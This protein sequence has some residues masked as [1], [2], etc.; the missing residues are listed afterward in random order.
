MITTNN[1]GLKVWNLTTDA[2]NHEQLADNWK[3]VDEHYHGDGT[4]VPIPTS[5]IQDGAI[6]SAK[7]APGVLSAPSTNSLTADQFVSTG[8]AD[9]L[10][11]SQ[12][13]LVRRGKSIITTEEARTNTA[14]GLL[15]TP[16]RVQ[17]LVVPTDGLIVIGFQGMVKSSSAA[18]G[19]AAIFI[20]SNQLKTAAAT[21]VVQEASTGSADTYY[22]YSTCVFGLD[23]NSSLGSY[24]GDVTTGQTLGNG[25]STTGLS[26][27]LCVVFANA[28]TYD[29]SIQ[30]KASTGSITA[31]NRKLWVWTVGF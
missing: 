5:G 21:P 8:V 10:G 15:T 4:G 13:G 26:G 1:M 6:T 19:K 18:A 16:D 28:G 29:I 3:K 7:L 2:Y 24:T 14:Y 9:V 30:Y 22:P 20:G 17:N 31:K 12:T 23:W 25:G 11:L 27:G